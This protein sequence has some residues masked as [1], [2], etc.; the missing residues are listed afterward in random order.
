[1]APSMVFD[2]ERRLQLV[3]GSPG[4]SSIINYV[5]KTLVGV[6]DW[7]LDVQSAIDLPNFGSRNGPDRDRGR[8]AY[9]GSF[10]SSS[11]AATTSGA[12]GCKAACTASS[13]CPAAG[14]AAPTRAARAGARGD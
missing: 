5:A 9:E 3:V 8:L 1:M 6:L 13:A 11:A 12:H 2:R 7:K 10:R 14:A 4:G